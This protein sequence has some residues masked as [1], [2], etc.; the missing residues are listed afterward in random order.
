MTRD[1]FRGKPAPVS[2]TWRD[3]TK[4]EPC[5]ICEKCRWC[6]ISPDGAMV[7]CRFAPSDRTTTDK[8]G[9]RYYI[10]KADGDGG[11]AGPVPPRPAP[12]P[13]AVAPVEVRDAV[14]QTLLGALPLTDAHRQA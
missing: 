4:G 9:V 6:R 14:Y 5:P 13:A 1:P 12:P 8:S 11:L 3:A 10:H 7:A 2:T